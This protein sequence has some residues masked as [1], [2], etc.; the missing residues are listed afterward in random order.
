MWLIE[1][2]GKPDV[3]RFKDFV[4]MSAAL[5]E[6]LKSKRT[7]KGANIKMRRA[8]LA[9]EIIDRWSHFKN[10]CLLG[11]YITMTIAIFAWLTSVFNLL[12]QGPFGVLL[13]FVACAMPP[14]GV[15]HGIR[16]WFGY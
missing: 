12:S 15:V 7:R 14:A 9:D 5:A 3:R 6:D 16:I 13:A 4:E 2:D 10:Q 11:Y 8:T 1:I